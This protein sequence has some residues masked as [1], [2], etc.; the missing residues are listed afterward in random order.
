[1]TGF[2]TKPNHVSGVS[3]PDWECSENMVRAKRTIW[4]EEDEIALQQFVIRTVKQIP[5]CCELS[6]VSSVIYGSG[7]DLMIIQLNLLEQ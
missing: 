4:W 3:M 2:Q 7:P 6:C 1:M 5:N